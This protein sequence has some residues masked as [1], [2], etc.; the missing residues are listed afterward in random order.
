MRAASPL[1]QFTLSPAA[2]AALLYLLAAGASEAGTLGSGWLP[3][4]TGVLR[5]GER[6][7]LGAGSQARPL[8][9]AEWQEDTALQFAD[10]GEPPRRP[11]IAPSERGLARR[12]EDA[13]RNLSDYAYLGEHPLADWKLVQR[14]LPAGSRTTLDRG[15]AL[16]AVLVEAIEKFR[17]AGKPP[18]E[19]LPKVWHAY[20]I[21]HD[22]YVENVSNREIMARLNISEGSF[23]RTR[24]A[25]LQALARLLQELEA[26]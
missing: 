13:L 6:L 22:A 10:L 24:R 5:L 14:R 18:A 23:N 19:P 7:R 20:Y 2:Q 3:T 4:E 25:A 12:V 21:L 17:P 9:L 8:T 26:A 16:Y 1:Q 11:T 15:K